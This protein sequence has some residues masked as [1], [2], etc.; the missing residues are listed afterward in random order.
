MDH[1]RGALPYITNVW[2]H[3]A[4]IAAD[5][6][7]RSGLAAGLKPATINQRLAIVRRVVN[8][9]FERGWLDRPIKIRL[10]ALN[11]ARHIY[12]TIQQVHALAEA[13]GD[14]KDAI[15]LLAYTG[16]RRGELFSLRKEQ[17]RDGC[18][19]L[20]VNNKAGRPRAIPLADPIKRIKIPITLTQQQLRARFEKA[21]VVI[22]MP[23]LHLHDLRHTTASLL[24]Q[25]G[26]SLTEVRDILGHSS[27]AVTNRY[28]HLAPEHLRDAISKLNATHSR[29]TA[30]RKNVSRGT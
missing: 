19:I 26:A 5:N 22:G 29:Y 7:K 10:L 15:L 21:R 14:A 25:A 12:L 1:A 27:F 2:L 11:N 18:L 28:A 13:A 17:K 8:I 3:D 16:L 6:I 24:I 4:Q 9:A 30:K 20:G 23:E